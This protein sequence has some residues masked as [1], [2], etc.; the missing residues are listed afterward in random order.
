[1]KS[2]EDLRCI[3]RQEGADGLIT[4]RVE[5]CRGLLRAKR[6]F[7]AARHGGERTALQAAKVWR[8]TTLAQLDAVCTQPP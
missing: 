8:D 7:S 1:M 6:Q 3:H 5:L 2:R 4:W